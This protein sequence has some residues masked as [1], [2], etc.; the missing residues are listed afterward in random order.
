MVENIAN[1]EELVVVEEKKIVNPGKE[2]AKRK[3]QIIKLEEKIAACEERIE[4]LKEESLKE[5]YASDYKQLEKFTN[6]I[7]DTEKEW[8]DLMEALAQLQ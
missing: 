5:E 4:D 2:E 8:E 6:Q 1:S 7:D 3:R